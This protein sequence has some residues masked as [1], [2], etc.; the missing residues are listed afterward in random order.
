MK[1]LLCLVLAA[2]VLVAA[3]VEAVPAS[4][5][6]QGRPATIVG[7]DG[8]IL[9]GTEGDDVIVT[10]P[11]S[12]V[13]AL[14]GDDVVCAV[15]PEYFLDIDAG[16]GDDV[17]DTTAAAASTE[18][19]HTELGT[20]ADRFVGG[21]ANDQVSDS[22][23]DQ[24]AQDD[25]A[26][27]LIHTGAGNDQVETGAEGVAN[28]DVV[29]LGAGRGGIQFRGTPG[30]TAHLRSRGA[31]FLSFQFDGTVGTLRVDNRRE[32]AD[33]DGARL[34][35]WDGFASFSTESSDVER[36]VLRGGDGAERF[37]GSYVDGLELD[38]RAGGGSDT[39]EVNSRAVGSVD[40]GRGRDLVYISEAEPTP[41]GSLGSDITADLGSGLVR[42]DPQ[43]ADS[44]VLSVD[45]VED[46]S[47]VGFHNTTLRGDRAANLLDVRAGCRST[48][49]GRAGADRLQRLET[50]CDE[51]DLPASTMR[52]DRGPDRLIGSEADDLMVGGPGRDVA[53]GGGG[54]DTCR[55]EV[56][57]RCELR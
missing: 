52:G 41:V 12:S 7:Q 42:I 27:D 22:E 4:P 34:V 32:Q 53:N 49:V 2:P 3:P 46:L 55:T 37:V 23:E 57:R 35:T 17:V 1:R 36:V 6:C 45:A 25:S 43:G 51:Q 39:V 13:R 33:L 40:G 21:P 19:L 44:H 24:G 38:V 5:T 18:G 47:V 30:G 8:S 26:P 20:G 29:D 31:G 56:R 14:G 54:T 9:V 10:G 48:L 50:T 16:P 11:A 28:N 15:D